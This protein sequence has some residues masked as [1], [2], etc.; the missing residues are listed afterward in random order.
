LFHNAPQVPAFVALE[1]GDFVPFFPDEVLQQAFPG[2]FAFGEAIGE[3][4]VEYGVFNPVRRL[5][6]HTLF[7][8]FTP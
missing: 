3:Y 1:G 4:L 7:L 6:L 5:N 8:A 2:L